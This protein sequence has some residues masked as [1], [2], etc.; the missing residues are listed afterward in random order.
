M[1]RSGDSAKAIGKKWKGEGNEREKEGRERKN[2]GGRFT[3]VATI[4]EPCYATAT[5][6]IRII[7]PKTSPA[8]TGALTS[9]T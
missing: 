6:T 1:D 3:S 4:F 2:T 9:E 8:H 5:Y 7:L